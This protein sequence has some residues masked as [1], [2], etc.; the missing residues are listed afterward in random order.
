MLIEG[1]SQLKKKIDSFDK[2]KDFDAPNEHIPS[3]DEV[4]QRVMVVYVYV[5][6]FVCVYMW[7]V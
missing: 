1:G 7:M 4:G 5:Y 2:A 3:V 6:A